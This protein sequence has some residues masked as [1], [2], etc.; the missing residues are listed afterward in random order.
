MAQKLRLTNPFAP[1]NT[2]EE[3]FAPKTSAKKKKTG[4]KNKS[5][6]KGTSEEEQAERAELRF[7]HGSTEQH[8]NQTAQCG[9]QQPLTEILCVMRCASLRPPTH[10]AEVHAAPINPATYLRDYL[11][12]P[13]VNEPD[14]QT[15]EK[16]DNEAVPACGT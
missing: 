11:F 3:E 8:R 4:S 9:N 16:P 2:E 15:D 7:G 10:H 1:S 6:D 5:A 14:E 13:E 12:H